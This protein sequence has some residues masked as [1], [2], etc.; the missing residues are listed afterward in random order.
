MFQILNV[1]KLFFVKIMLLMSS[2]S[3]I[4][5]FNKISFL[6]IRLKSFKFKNCL[7]FNIFVLISYKQISVKFSEFFSKLIINKVFLISFMFNVGM[8]SLLLLKKLI[9]FS[10]FEYK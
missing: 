4:E 2:N 9:D 1:L 10:F 7:F 5:E 8:F 6:K 3:M